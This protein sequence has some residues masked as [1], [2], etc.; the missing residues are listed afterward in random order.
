MAGKQKISLGIIFGGRSGE[1]EVSLKSAASVIGAL[2]PREYEIT[3][4]GITKTGKLAGVSEMRDMLPPELL[5][6]I[7][8]SPAIESNGNQGIRITSSLAEER[9]CSGQAPQIIFPLLHGPYGEDGTIQGLL[10]IAGIPYIGCGVLASSV[11][12][13]KDVMKRL[14]LQAGIPTTP[15]RTVFTG[16]LEKNMESLKRSVER[17]FGYPMFSKPANLGSSVG[18][19]KIH[20]E[21]EFEEALRCSAQ[22]DRKILI[23]KGIDGCELECAILGNDC[24]QASVVGEVISAHEFY[25]YAAKYINPESTLKIPAGIDDNKAEEI[26]ELALRS[27]KAID[28]SGL[29][30]VDFFLERSTCRVLVNEINTMPGFTPISMYAKLWAASGISFEQLVRRLIRLGEERFQERNARKISAGEGMVEG[31]Q[32]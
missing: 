20:S 1:H 8:F 6:R 16:D 9:A 31:N 28:G 27:F 23:E 15:F 14:F 19:C 3:A 32:Y 5:S 29:A 13:D 24:P 21:R 10:E 4:I 25:D 11:G 2:D 17:E 30:R 7:A 26:K 22:F 18:I 12:M